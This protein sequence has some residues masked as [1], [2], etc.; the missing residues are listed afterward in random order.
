VVF[1]TIGILLRFLRFFAVFRAF[2]RTMATSHTSGPV[3]QTVKRFGGRGH[4]TVWVP[5]NIGLSA[6]SHFDG[7]GLWTKFPESK[8]FMQ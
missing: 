4:R 6:E 7:S 3:A 8:K 1:R 2:S 5:T